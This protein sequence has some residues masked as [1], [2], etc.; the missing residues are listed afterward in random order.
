MKD[1]CL[2]RPF[3]WISS[4]GLLFLRA[5]LCVHMRQLRCNQVAEM[6][7]DAFL[8]RWDS[9]FSAPIITAIWM[10]QPSKAP[11]DF[12]ILGFHHLKL[13]HAKQSASVCI[14]LPC[15]TPKI[16]IARSIASAISQQA[17][18]A[19]TMPTSVQDF[20]DSNV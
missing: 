2:L 17:K 18:N 3:Q 7:C 10:P 16:G 4:S 13:K 12:R 9:A 19:I 15:A 6:T 8:R 20:L 1:Y 11:V 14:S 5:C